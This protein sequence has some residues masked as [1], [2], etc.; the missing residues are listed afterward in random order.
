M[1]Y[2]CH[3]LICGKM[4]PCKNIVP[5]LYIMTNFHNLSPM[6]LLRLILK[7][8]SICLPGKEDHLKKIVKAHYYKYWE[9]GSVKWQ[10]INTEFLK[11]LLEK[12]SLVMK[13]FYLRKAPK[14][15]LL[16]A[17]FSPLSSSMNSLTHS[18]SSLTPRVPGRTA[19][20]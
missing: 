7:S 20:H 16:S 18:F 8:T 2:I 4:V 12:S 17:A 13:F 5:L 9:P 19:S 6:V 10:Y 1:P 15:I 11:M 14:S 3:S